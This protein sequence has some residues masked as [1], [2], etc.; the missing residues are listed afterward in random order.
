MAQS[1]LVVVIPTYAPGASIWPTL[2][3]LNASVRKWTDQPYLL[4]L[5]DSSPDDSICDQARKWAAQ[6]SCSLVIDY[7]ATRR[8]IKEALNAALSKKEVAEADYVIF[9]NDDVVFEINCV[10]NIIRPLSEDVT[11][12]IA[13]G[14]LM[15]DPNYTGGRRRAGAWQMD[16][17][18]RIARSL[19]SRAIRAEG[20]I[21]ATRGTFAGEFRYPIGSGNIADDVELQNYAIQNDIVTLN[22]P[23]AVVYK[24]PPLGFSEF[25]L[26]TQRFHTAS[27]TA[28]GTR[29]SLEVRFRAL[30][31]SLLRSPLGALHYF[32]YRVA[33]FFGAGKQSTSSQEN[34]NRASSTW[35]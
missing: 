31:I 26:Q 11:A 17:V 18:G 32:A 2:T 13:V 3:S 24:I 12:K 23:E 9:T 20:A 10:S 29:P 6:V 7:S 28:I 22:V 5:S 34:W 35:R 8:F 33:L 25:A 27:R 16:V 21:W 15:P 14:S 30:L 19:P 1:S 4:V